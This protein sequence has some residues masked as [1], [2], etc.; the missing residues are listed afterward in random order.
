M[1]NR[2][3]GR[4][5]SRLARDRAGA[6]A[7]EFA[8]V[9]APF[10]A[11]LV[12]CLQTA[13]IFYA[14]QVLETGVSDAARLIKTGQA[15][16]GGLGAD[17]FKQAVCDEIFGLFDCMAG[18][19]VDVRTVSDFTSAQMDKPVVDGELKDDFTFDPGVGGDI[20]LVRAFYEWP[21]VIPMLGVSIADLSNG[22]YLLSAATTFR[23]EPF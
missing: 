22:N 3:L 13:L 6:T 10:F 19:K 11:L 4:S 15:Q 20:V 16:S 23:N 8:L 17:S 12:A 1:R 2:S 9:A 18:L 7:V 21:I 14:S 5:L